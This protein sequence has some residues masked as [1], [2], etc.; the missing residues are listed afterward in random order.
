MA[1]SNCLHPARHSHNTADKAENS[2][3]RDFVRAGLFAFLLFSGLVATVSGTTIVAL[4]TPDYVALGADSRMAVMSMQS[5]ESTLGCKIQQ[6]NHILPLLSHIYA[7]FWCFN[8]NL[9]HGH[10]EARL[11]VD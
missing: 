11:V 6:M 10:H 5:T 1:G 8:P 4:R 3:V 9:R 7:A 2:S